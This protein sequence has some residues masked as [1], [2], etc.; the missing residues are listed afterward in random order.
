MLHGNRFRVRRG[1]WPLLLVL[2]CAFARPAPGAEVFLSATRSE[3]E[4]IPL[5]ILQ[6]AAPPTL[7]QR[8]SEIQTV[9]ESDLRR[10]QVF[11]VVHPT[12]FPELANGEEPT[13]EVIQKAGKQ[14]VQAAVW[15]ALSQKGEDLV[16]EGRVYDGKGGQMV[17]GKRYLG[18]AAYL[19][20]II[21]RF[22]DEIVF[23]YTGERG[24]AET[25]VAFG[26]LVTGNKELY[27]MDYDGYNV[28]KITND[29][30]LDLSPRW[31]PDGNWITYT[32]YRGGGPAIYTLDLM[33]G[34]LWKVVGY[35]GLNISPAWSPSG[36]GLLFAGTMDGPAQIYWVDK[37]GKGLKRLTVDE[38][39]N[40]SP[41]WSPP[42]TEIA[43]T[44]NRG[45]S[46]QIYVMNADGS[47]VRRLTFAGD[48]N[49]TP[50]WSPKG[51]AIAYTCRVDGRLR[52]CA[53]SP[54]GSKTAQLTD[55]PGEDEAPTWSPDGKHL[56]FSSTRMSEG[57][58][59]M[60]NADGM[61]LERLTFSGAK[62]NN[63]A[64]SP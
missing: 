63:P 3:A 40:L 48:Y 24:I 43:F 55:G 59:F 64:W 32:S 60:V 11:R 58:L 52:I 54:D 42:G 39:D 57:D 2:L 29:R 62:N 14:D 46:P 36:Q 27:L 35:A 45:G 37:E 5:G 7:V 49:T 56:I 30:N 61:D 8:S 19:R 23:Q 16:L 13:T 53:I 12:P 44:S 28:R 15:I 47:N 20:S 33:S 21:H 6:V 50:A 17:M 26:S 38:S 51:T 25:R 9:L 34:R 31:S 10:S 22:S 18:Q 1:V 4:K 41:S